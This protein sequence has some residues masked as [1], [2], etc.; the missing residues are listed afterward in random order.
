MLKAMGDIRRYP[1]HVGIFIDPE[2]EEENN[3]EKKFWCGYGR[4]AVGS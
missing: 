2:L 4:F 3:E 1:L